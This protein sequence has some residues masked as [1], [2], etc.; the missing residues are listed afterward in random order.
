MF[1][2]CNHVCFQVVELLVQGIIIALELLALA[3]EL[4]AQGI[5]LSL[6]LLAQGIALSLELLAQGIAPAL[7][8]CSA[9]SFSIARYHLLLRL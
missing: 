7:V 8:S 4:F 5:A 2:V 9:S 3:L 6:E 1:F